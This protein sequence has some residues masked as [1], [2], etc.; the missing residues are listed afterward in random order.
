MEGDRVPTGR[1]LR[2]RKEKVAKHLKRGANEKEKENFRKRVIRIPLHKPFEEAYYTHRLWMFFRETWEKEEDIKRMLCAARVKLRM[3]ITLKKKSDPGQFAIPCTVKGG[4]FAG[5]VHFCGLFPEELMRN[6]ERPRVGAVCNSQTNQLCPTLIDPNAH[7]DPI[8]VK[9]P[10]MSS[11]RI[12]DPGII[13]AFH[14]GVEYETEYS[15]SIETQT[16]TSI[17]SG[18]QK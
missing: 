14:C 8:P 2:R 17:D 3:R 1:T 15:A 7:Y 6:C 18:N 13:A 9:N 4:A 16:A 5:I 10:H 12:N 11:R